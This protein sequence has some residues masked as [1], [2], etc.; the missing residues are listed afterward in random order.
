M[1]G[2]AV[3]YLMDGINN[4]DMAMAGGGAAFIVGSVL[5][6]V[7]DHGSYM[8]AKATREHDRSLKDKMANDFDNAEQGEGLTAV[9]NI[10][11]DGQRSVDWGENKP[12]EVTTHG[13][14]VD[15]NNTQSYEKYRDNSS[16][17]LT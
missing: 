3:S 9:V 8:K 6:A 12:S 4:N 17:V 13:L 11:I 5:M 10:T 14:N 2:R 1:G 7:K 15:A 16:A